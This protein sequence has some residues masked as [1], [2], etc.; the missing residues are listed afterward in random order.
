MKA[1]L[2]VLSLLALN[3]PGIAAA[4]DLPDCWTTDGNG[5]GRNPRG[6]EIADG[7][8]LIQVDFDKISK[9]ELVQVM[10]KVK[11]GNLNHVGY[12][13]IFE[14]DFMILHV[15]ARDDGST[16]PKP[17]SR[18][19]LKRRASEQLAEIVALPAVPSVDCNGIAHPD[20]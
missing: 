2:Y 15:E 1:L 18:P 19:E 6:E 4:A 17:I 10:S 20:N 9:E 7:Q 5:V 3:L 13:I 8:W 12:P 16:Y 11:R 14:P